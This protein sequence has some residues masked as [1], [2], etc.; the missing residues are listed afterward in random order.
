M[1]IRNG[2]V[3]NSS[4]SSFIVVIP[5]DPK[6]RNKLL[7]QCSEDER[8]VIDQELA[9]VS[10]SAIGVAHALVSRVKYNDNATTLSRRSHNDI[11]KLLRDVINKEHDTISKIIDV[12]DTYD[13]D[14]EKALIMCLGYNIISREI[15]KKFIGNDVYYMTFSDED[16]GAEADMRSSGPGRQ[17]TYIQDDE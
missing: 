7:D 8:P 5:K 17:F 1:K 4:S 16:G 9:N 2:F 6:E 11:D 13:T 10:A 12:D 15:S 3:S 14:E